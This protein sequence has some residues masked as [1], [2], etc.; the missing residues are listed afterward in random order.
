MTKIGS[1]LS[2]NGLDHTHTNGVFVLQGYS[3][4]LTAFVIEHNGERHSLT[5][6]EF[7]E[8]FT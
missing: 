8:L 6:N 7:K 5:A 4:S 1:V 3:L 2:L